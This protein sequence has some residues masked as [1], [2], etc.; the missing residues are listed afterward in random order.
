MPS[1][2]ISSCFFVM[3][4]PVSCLHWQGRRLH[5]YLWIKNSQKRTVLQLQSRYV[6][7][8]Q[9]QLCMDLRFRMHFDLLEMWML[10]GLSLRHYIILKIWDGSMS[11]VCVHH[12]L[13][14]NRWER[15]PCTCLVWE[16]M[17]LNSSWALTAS[18]KNRKGFPS[19][20]LKREQ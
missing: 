16:G 15:I 7:Y 18:G 17:A 11:C 20:Q 1:C 3:Q 14:S 10:R 2:Y 4:F 6:R 12:L 8:S 5:F 19:T 9:P 13:I